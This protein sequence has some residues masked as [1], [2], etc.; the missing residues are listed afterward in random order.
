MSRAVIYYTACPAGMQEGFRGG[1]QTVRTLRGFF[2]DACQAEE[3]R[4][5]LGILGL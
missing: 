3:A 2:T 1:G 4:N 5:V